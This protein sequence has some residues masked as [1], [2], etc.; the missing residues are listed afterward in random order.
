M[1]R[2]AE[3]LMRA[4][5]NESRLRESACA[6]CVV[7]RAGVVARAGEAAGRGERGREAGS[8]FDLVVG[9]A[10]G[11]RAGVAAG[12]RAGVVLRVVSRGAGWPVC[13]ADAI[14]AVPTT[15]RAI[16]SATARA[17]VRCGMVYLY[18]QGAPSLEGGT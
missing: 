13:C 12:R 10:A 5:C 18:V 8:V 6:R 4:W 1:A 7:S 14:G 3:S 11:F 2:C 16:A 9:R 15:R 17:F